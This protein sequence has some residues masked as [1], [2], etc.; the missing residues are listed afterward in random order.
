MIAALQ[1]EAWRRLVALRARLPHALLLHGTQ[2]VGKLA[3]AERFAQLLVCEAAGQ[4]SEPCGACSACRWFLGTNHPDVRYVEPEA[5][6]RYAAQADEDDDAPAKT[7]KPS[8]E[9]KIE[10][11]RALADFVNVGS[12][13]G[14]RRVA[15]IHPAE[16]MNASS[17]N[18]LLKSLEEPPTGAMFLLVSH[19]PARLLPTIRSRC[20]AVPVT[21]PAQKTS[22]AWLTAQAVPEPVRWLAFSGGAPRRALEIAT[23]GHAEAIDGL[24]RALEASD[25][26]AAASIPDRETLELLAEVLQ[27]IALDRA[28]VDLAGRSR[29]LPELRLRSRAQAK[30]WL[31]FARAMGRNRLLAKHPL[32]PRLF[33]AEMLSSF[34]GR[35][36][37]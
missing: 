22:L 24:L 34:P 21:L 19:R 28:F 25:F 15:I 14:G 10:Q 6:G 2:G 4:G 16:D 9:I 17:A 13:R 12:H 27:K 37:S 3:L 23:G 20:V 30:Q 18:S 7:S 33:A 32:N 11:V 26:E 31:A 1:P 29:F 8:T 5:L 35:S 36:S